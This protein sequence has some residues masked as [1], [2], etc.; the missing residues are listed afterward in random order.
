VLLLVVLVVA[1]PEQD[2]LLLLEQMEQL[3]PV[4]VAVV[5]IHFLVTVQENRVVQV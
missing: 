1:E 4:A 5:E 3:I 2:G